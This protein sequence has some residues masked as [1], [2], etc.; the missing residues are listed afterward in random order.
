MIHVLVNDTQKLFLW[1]NGLCFL[2]MVKTFTQFLM[3]VMPFQFQF[4]LLG[5]TII[6][7]NFGY[8][9]FQIFTYNTFCKGWTFFS[10]INI[11]MIFFL[12]LAHNRLRY[13]INIYFFANL[14]YHTKTKQ[15]RLDEKFHKTL[16]ALT[17][18]SKRKRHK[19][20][21]NIKT[22]IQNLTPLHCFVL[23]YFSKC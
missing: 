8:Q 2:I 9:V 4:M 19:S 1:L 7:S 23:E 15:K 13:F 14:Q 17:K 11:E 20:F 18:T 22:N 21:K 6:F 3:L 10:Y 16:F 12:Q 5:I